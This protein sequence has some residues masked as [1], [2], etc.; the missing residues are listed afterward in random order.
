MDTNGFPRAEYAPK[1]VKSGDFV[2]VKMIPSKP[3]CGVSPSSSRIPHIQKLIS[4]FSTGNVPNKSIDPD[5]PVAYH[6][7]EAAAY[8]AAVQAAIL[9]G[10]PAKTL[11]LVDVAPLSMDIETAGG[12]MTPLIKRNTTIPAKKSEIFSTYS[13]NQPGILMVFECKRARTKDSNLLGKFELT[14]IFPSARGVPSGGR[15]FQ[16]SVFIRYH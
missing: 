8:G 16:G 1:F 7:D 9:T 14:G 2:I 10:I 3:L 13:D 11:L 15:V 12:G 6:S 4:D 5:D